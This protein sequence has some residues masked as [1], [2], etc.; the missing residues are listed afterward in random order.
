MTPLDFSAYIAERTRDFTGREWVFAEI[1]RWRAVH[2]APRYFIITGEP[3]I[4][5][6]AIAARL[7]QVRALDAYHFCI[8]RQADTIDPLNFAR[9]I[10][11]QFTCIDGFARGILEEQG[12]YVDV[13]INVR[14]NYGQIIGVQIE[15]LVVE[16]PSA[17]IAFNRAVLDPLRQLYTGGFDRPLL[18]L[19]DALDEAVQQRGPETIVDLLANAHGLPSQVRFVL[20]SR[21]EG[22]V[23]RHFERLSI[24]HLVLEAGGAEN[25]ADVQAYVRYRLDNFDV[26]RSRLLEETVDSDV[27]VE[28]VTEASQG[29]FLYLVWLLRSVEEGA[30]RF[31]TLEV[32]PEGLDGVYREFLRTRTP[33][34]DIHTWRKWYRPL[35]GMLAVA[36]APLSGEQLVAFTGL[37]KQSARD[38]LD[39]VQQFLDPDG[40]GENRHQLY[41]QSVID[42]FRD[43]TRAGEFWIDLPPIHGQIADYYLG[44]CKGDWLACDDYGLR[45]LTVHLKE[46]GAWDALGTLLTD[47]DFLESQTS[48]LQI[49]TTLAVLQDALSLLPGNSRAFA[50][51]RSLLH[52]MQQESHNLRQWDSSRQRTR[53]SQQLL[54][55]AMIGSEGDIAL[56][57]DKR[58]EDLR[59]AY[60]V[61]QWSTVLPTPALMYTWLPKGGTIWAIGVTPVGDHVLSAADDGTLTVWEADTGLQKK[62]LMGHTGRVR[63]VVVTPDGQRAISA[64]ADSTIRIWYLETG[65]QQSVLAGHT[66][67]VLALAITADGQRVISGSADRDLKVW[68]LDTGQLVHTLIGHTSEVR[69]VA[70]LPAGRCVISA[71]ADRTLKLWDIDKGS[72]VCTLAGGRGTLR[73]VAVTPDGNT[74]IAAASDQSLQVWDLECRQML[75]LLEGHKGRVRCVAALDREGKVVSGGEDRQ[76][77]IW[78]LDTGQ[79]ESTLAGH[80]GT[81]WAVAEIPGRHQLVSASDDQTIKIWDLTANLASPASRGHAGRVLDLAITKDGQRILSASQD[82]TIKVWRVDSGELEHTLDSHQSSVRQIAVL[83]DGRQ[84]ISASQDRTLIV[85]NLDSGEPVETLS[86]HKSSVVALAVTPMGDRAI[87]ASADRTLRIWD[88]SSGCE[89]HKLAEHGGE[90]S[91]VAITSDGRQAVSGSIDGTVRVWDLIDGTCIHTLP[92]HGGPVLAVALTRDGRRIISG[93][94]DAHIRIWDMQSGQMIH[95]LAGHTASV[96]AICPLPASDRFVSASADGTLI[97]WDMGSG[98]PVLNLRGHSDRISAISVLANRVISASADRT[99]RVWDLE[100]GQETVCVALE[101]GLLSLGVSVSGDVI[102]VGDKAGNVYCLRMVSP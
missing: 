57:A 56:L 84:A 42:F 98:D 29:N 36:Q 18:I 40:L 72:E 53:F 91:A 32:L 1:D 51:I 45:Y 7:T 4:G 92:E 81:I 86:G 46:T 25:Q 101:S 28:R 27:F 74:A 62:K 75:R 43:E 23:L 10:S 49:H 71:S 94:V 48:R 87:S 30:Q 39:D 63:A 54:Y 78:N 64:G 61:P 52:L 38:A 35:L 59:R 66:D 26:L 34:E 96:M 9:S 60:L 6:T 65:D 22:E 20:T 99:L 15:N 95:R 44:R 11:R 79:A 83:P 90:V 16:A 19:V 14:E 93:S 24:P 41:H 82:N 76:L 89:V 55:R 88:L 67:E 5:K 13:T 3:G 8:A 50:I 102:A 85:W 77:R 37:D 47:L 21:P 2:D 97:V 69:S 17:A 68:S 73:S 70:V 33:G 12:I 80:A 31:D 100:T 58:L